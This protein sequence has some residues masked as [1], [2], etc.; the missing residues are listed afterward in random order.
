M[1][2]WAWRLPSS[3][4]LRCFRLQPSDLLRRSLDVFM[5]GGAIVTLG[6]C[7]LLISGTFA[8]GYYGSGLFQI[9]LASAFGAAAGVAY[10]L[11]VIAFYGITK[12]ITQW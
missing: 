7:S 9:V 5:V 1:E 2:R 6:Y 10:C 3:H 8:A 4:S 12:C 11:L